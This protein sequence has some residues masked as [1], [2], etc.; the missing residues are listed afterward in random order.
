M[1]EDPSPFWEVSEQVERFAGREPDQRLLR[2]VESYEEPARVRVLDLGCA[3]GRNTVVLAQRG[4]DVHAVDSSRAMVERTRQRVAKVLG[5]AAAQERVRVG[6]MDSLAE[7]GSGSFDL[8]VALGVYHN[9]T[10]REEWERALSETERILRPGGLVLVASFS[11]RSDP[12][13]EGLRPAPGA[14]HVYEGF[15]AGRMYLMEAEAFDAEMARHGLLPAVATE[16]VEAPTD[17]GRRVTVNGLYR[18][19]AA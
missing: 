11:P 15:E 18:K 7:H 2:L 9:A 13:G 1:A 4:F 17:S 3:A 8:I 5:P 16:T 10:C 14:P 12:R 19:K 6:R